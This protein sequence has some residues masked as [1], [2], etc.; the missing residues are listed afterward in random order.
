MQLLTG[1]DLSLS[2]HTRELFSHV[3]F[4]VENGAHIGLVGANGCG[5]TSFFR[6]LTGELNA[7]S[8]SISLSREARMAYM[9]QFLAAEEDESLQ[10]AVMH[11]FAPLQA[12][13]RQLE[14]VNARL[15][16]NDN[17]SQ[18]LL[19]EQHRLQERY[20]DQG[21]YTYKAR[22]RSTLLGVGFSESDLL[23]PISALSGGQRS[24]AAL[25]KVLLTDANL[26]LLDEPTN[27]LDIQGVEWLEGFLSSYRGS[28]ILISHDRYFLDRVTTETWAM[29]HQRMS[30]YKGNY[31][32]H[33]AQRDT[34][35]ESIRRRYE[36]QMR[37]INRIQAVIEQQRRFNQERNYVTIASKQKQIERLKA[38]LVPPESKERTLHFHFNVPPPG[39]NDVLELHQVE[40][41]FDGRQIFH[42]ADLRL[43]K[44]E[45]VF[46]LGANGCGKSTL[47]KMI[48]GKLEPDRGMV[49]LGVN[50]HTAYYDQ[51][52]DHLTGPL[53]ILEYFT[54]RYPRL[55]QTEI[56]TMLGSFLFSG[57]AVEK[58]L[59]A[60]SG[61]EKARLTLMELLL[62]PANF[63]LLD[64]PT[65]HLDIA[66]MEAVEQAL[67]DYPGTILAVSHDR[68]LI[69]KLA[70][71]VYYMQEDGLRETLGN[72]DDYLE[73][74]QQEQPNNAAS[75]EDRPAAHS[76]SSAGSSGGFSAG[77]N[78]SSTAKSSGGEDYRRRKEEQAA[79]RK[80]QKRREKL[81]A[82]IA[83]LE[84]ELDQL[85]QQLND[86]ALAADYQ[87]LME[88]AQR[89][90][91][92]ET[93]LLEKMEEQEAL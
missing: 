22:L 72:Y 90:E 76:A 67:L 42:G 69:N 13:E 30:C 57:E 8:G 63:L 18:A 11:V 26:L 41:S 83:K 87:R 37:E 84:E 79:A 50:I 19:E 9:E 23:L 91:E 25:A 56:R 81:E 70:N 43:S 33:L 54:N 1:H 45:R 80:E 52:H 92:V 71:R 40:K 21:G 20:G 77:A 51:L 74:V 10:A 88:L 7:D 75:G 39:G 12:L 27:H 55:T 24:R 31:S 5:K 93:L 36:N 46:L 66:S 53:S 65:N 17:P 86:P 14:E 73:H 2:F 16:H 49:R 28:F 29:H 47:M 6:L 44:G 48:A 3:S 34:D 64:E 62:A 78:P 85:S 60:L 61:G 82:E 68:Y 15:E 32:A 35:E 58:N 38:D 4:G 59:S 89:Q